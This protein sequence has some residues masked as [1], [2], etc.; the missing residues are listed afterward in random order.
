[1]NF[2]EF[3]KK[4]LYQR[5]LFEE[6]CDEIMDTVIKDDTLESMND[7]WDDDMKSYP[8]TMK[9]IIWIAVKKAAIEYIEKNC[10]GAWF[11]ALFTDEA[12]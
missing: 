2:K 11:K 3:F 12:E 6:Q 5:G 8:D 1:M 9:V 7:R 4:E 10:P